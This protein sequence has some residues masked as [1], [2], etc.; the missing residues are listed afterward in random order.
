[1]RFISFLFLATIIGALP[2]RAASPE[3]T[4][5]IPAAA[6]EAGKDQVHAL[7]NAFAR[8]FETVAPSVVIIEVSKKSDG[9]ENSAFDDLFF[10]GPPDDNNSRRNPRGF[11][12]IR[13]EGSGFIVR[14]DGVI[15]TN[16][17]VVE[18][19]DKIDVKLKDGREFAGK[20]VGT[21]EKTDIAVVK[22]DAK[23]LPVVQLGD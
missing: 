18:G 8:V 19:A 10:Q 20:I 3:A 15:F 5:T 17:H 6:A 2:L 9:T 22:I 7:N 13:S 1:M 21:D 16:F 11:Q 14:P 12:P 23:D 4:P